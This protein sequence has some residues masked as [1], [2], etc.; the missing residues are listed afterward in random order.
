[1]KALAIFQELGHEAKQRE[2]SQLLDRLG[3]G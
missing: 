3:G 2:T 1:V